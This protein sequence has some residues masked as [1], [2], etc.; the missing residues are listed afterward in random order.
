MG[1]PDYDPEEL[2][3]TIDMNI[4][5]PDGS[6]IYHFFTKLLKISS[7]LQTATGRKLGEERHEFM[8]KFLRQYKKE[9]DLKKNEFHQSPLNLSNNSNV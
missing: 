7:L 6:P 1:Y 4:T 8:V 9:T 3:I 5:G 2:P